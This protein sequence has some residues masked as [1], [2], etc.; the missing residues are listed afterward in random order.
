MIEGETVLIKFRH[1]IRNVSSYRK[2]LN[3]IR[4][5]LISKIKYIIASSEIYFN[6]FKSFGKSL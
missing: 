3:L 4:F 6:V 1:L 2:D 5:I